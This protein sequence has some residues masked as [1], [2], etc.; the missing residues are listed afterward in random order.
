MENAS[1]QISRGKKRLENACFPHFPVQMSV[2]QTLFLVRFFMLLYCYCVSKSCHFDTILYLV[3]VVSNLLYPN[4]TQPLFQTILKYYSFIHDSKLPFSSSFTILHT[5][6]SD[7]AYR[8]DSLSY[9]NSYV[10]VPFNHHNIYSYFGLL[11]LT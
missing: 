2:T 1:K 10:I 5:N 7:S 9:N 3:N 8:P 6:S 4:C 11:F